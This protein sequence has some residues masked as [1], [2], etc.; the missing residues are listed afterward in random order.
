MSHSLMVP[1]STRN[2]TQRGGLSVFNQISTIMI[3]GIVVALIFPML[4]MP[5]IGVNKTSW[6]ILMCVLSILALPLTLIEYYFTKERITEEKAD[7]KEQI[8]YVDIELKAA[9]AIRAV[10][11]YTQLRRTEFYE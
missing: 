1:L 4:I 8:L 5:L 7:D 6:I 2:T 3:S 9:S 11:P 10:R